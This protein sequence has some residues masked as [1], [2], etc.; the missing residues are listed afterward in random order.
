[1]VKPSI[2]RVAIFVGQ[3]GEFRNRAYQDQVHQAFIRLPM[4]GM[5]LRLVSVG[6]AT[7]RP[8]HDRGPF[9]SSPRRRC[10]KP[11]KTS[12]PNS[13]HVP[14]EEVGRSPSKSP[15]ARDVVADRATGRP[16]AGEYGRSPQTHVN[17]FLIRAGSYGWHE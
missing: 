2:A 11:N 7:T 4:L 1:M 12:L 14:D 5:Q 8:S 17:E 13:V 3:R 9:A 10:V 16:R 15:A 6:L